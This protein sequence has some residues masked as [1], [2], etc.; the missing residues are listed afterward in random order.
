[1]VSDLT[2]DADAL[3]TS[4]ELHGVSN[5]LETASADVSCSSGG[6]VTVATNK[7]DSAKEFVDSEVC[8]VE[9]K[10]SGAPDVTHI[11]SAWVDDYREESPDV[12]S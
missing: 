1:M 11:A 8:K 4:P 2:V 5:E 6:L 3:T 7:I 9:S 12:S 10:E